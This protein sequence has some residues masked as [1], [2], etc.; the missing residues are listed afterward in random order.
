M[1]RSLLLGTALGLALTGAAWA[2]TNPRTGEELAAEQDYTYWMLDAAKSLDPNLLTSVED[3]DIVRSLIEGLYNEDANGGLVP[4]V[5]LSHTISEDLTTYTFTLR[6]DAKWSNGDPVVA[7]DFVYAWQRITD[8]ALASEYAWYIELMQVVN[9]G[10]ITRGEKPASELGIKAIDDHTLEVKILAPLPYFPSM[11]TH[12]STFPLHRATVEKFGAEWTKPE[13]YVGN[14]AYVLKEHLV[15]EKL[16]MEKSPTY[17]D[18]AN[19]IM[20]PITAVTIND[21]NAAWTRWVA[22]ELDRSTVPSGQFPR[23]KAEYPDEVSSNPTACSYTYIVNLGEGVG[24][25]ALK[26]VRVR[27]ALSLALNRDII[28]DNILQ[29]GQIPAYSWTPGAMNGFVMPTMDVASMTQAERDEKAKALMAEAGFGADNPLTFT[30]NYNTSEGHQKIAVAIQQMWKQTLGVEMT[31]QNF[32]WAV[33][34]DKMHAG[35]FDMARYAWCGDYNEASTFLD[36]WTSYSGNNDTKYS[37]PEYDKLM[38]DAK[39]MADPNPNYTAA[40]GL[41]ATDMPIIP[42]YHYTTVRAVKKDIKGLSSTNI[43]GT[44]YAKDLYRVAQ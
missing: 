38:K 2:D 41:L 44:W 39:T 19:V 14:G 34:T 30:M 23:L 3:A 33:H 20:S 43:L 29:A 12:S 42:I 36:L 6:T 13:N 7:G 28:V 16:V 40:E 25:P 37:N 27:Q 32:E 5:A 11:L 4:G 1:K 31:P 21:E 10:E 8:P 35:D 24:N 15:G 26:D 17:W 18:A 9:A 22:G